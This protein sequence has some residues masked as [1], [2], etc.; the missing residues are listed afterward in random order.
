MNKA[1]K[2]LILLLFGF[3]LL[4]LFF[5]QKRDSSSYAEV[6]YQKEF[7]LQI[8]LETDLK[9][10]K[11][12]GKLGDVYLEAGDGKIRVLEEESPKHLC[13]RRGYVSQVGDTIVCLPNEIVIFLKGKKEF[14]AILR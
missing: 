8:D 6:Y 2:V 7:V 10:Y 11:V 14:D 13:S 5:S 4:G 12:R 3:G 1:D 9:Q